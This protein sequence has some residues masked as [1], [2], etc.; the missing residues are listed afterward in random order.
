[1]KE[2]DR[3]NTEESFLSFKNH[4]HISL[5]K[6]PIKPLKVILHFLSHTFVLWL[7]NVCKFLKDHIIH[8]QIH[9]D[10]DFRDTQLKKVSEHSV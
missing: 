4:S 2:Y 6:R 7:N 10:V 8:G 1:M 5:T 3:Q 9:I